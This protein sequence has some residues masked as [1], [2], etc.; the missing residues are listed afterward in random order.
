MP[1]RRPPKP[2]GVQAAPRVRGQKSPKRSIN[3]LIREGPN[4]ADF[5]QIDRQIRRIH[6][7]AAAIL[8]AADVEFSLEYAITLRLPRN[9][10]DT[11]KLLVG[12][13]G[14]LSGFYSKIHLAYAMGIVG[15][16]DL[17]GLNII[18]RVRN[19]FAHAPR[20]IDFSAPEIRDEC[21]KIRLVKP[22]TN[23]D[24]SIIDSNSALRQRFTDACQQL[25]ASIVLA[26]IIAK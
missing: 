21:S 13:D 8:L 16:D 10:E 1:T 20:P 24:E 4:R 26:P 22:P 7:R 3:T 11:N 19:A 18:R 14:P 17:N 23:D 12:R 5:A 6:P 2:P 9:D 25:S 15:D